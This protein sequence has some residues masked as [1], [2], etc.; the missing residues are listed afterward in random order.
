MLKSQVFFRC[1]GGDY[2]V[3]TRCPFDGWSSPEAEEVT[4]ALKHLSPAE[5]P[6]I[7]RL[8][9][10]GVSE[11]ALERVIIVEFGDD[12]ARFD[13]MAPRG[14]SIKGKWVELKDVGPELT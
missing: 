13:A 14:Y 8:K 4:A 6:S 12:R 5:S 11:T 7:Q 9:E 10:A 2:F 1:N 3:G